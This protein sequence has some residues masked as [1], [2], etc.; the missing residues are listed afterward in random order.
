MREREIR[1]LGVRDGEDG[2]L[3]G[4]ESWERRMGE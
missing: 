1:E 3:R 2:A 4:R